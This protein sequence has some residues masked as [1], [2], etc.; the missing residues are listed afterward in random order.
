VITVLVPNFV[1]AQPVQ[2]LG[3]ELGEHGSV[4]GRVNNRNFCLRRQVQMGSGNHDRLLHS[5]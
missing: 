5:G 3:Y 4:P 2:R 1:E